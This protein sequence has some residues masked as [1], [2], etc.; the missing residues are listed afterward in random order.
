MKKSIIKVALFAA[1]AL[2]V[3]SCKSY[4]YQVYDVSSNNLKLQENS[5]VYE[6]E[7]CKVL[8]N[9]W[10]NNGK[11]KFAIINKTDKDIFVNM[12]Q[13]FY[14][15]NGQAV[16]YYQGRTYTT[17]SFNESTYVSTTASGSGSADGFWGKDVYFEDAQAFAKAKTFKFVK[18][19]ANSVTTKEK[20]IVCIPA[21]CYKI[22]NYYSVNPDRVITCERSKDYPSGNYPVGSYTQANT[23][24]SFKNRIAYGFTKNDVADKH[25][26]NDFWISG[27]TNYSQDA[28]TENYKDKKECYGIKSSEKGKRFKIGTPSKFY[29]LYMDERSGGFGNT[30]K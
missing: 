19:V 18:A 21:K 30:S 16:D 27:I 29:K 2:S 25:I 26:D 22:F 14:V 17:Q 23:P 10:S 5:L 12:G 3:S 13:S 15:V 1:I 20:E 7:D 8:Y 11:L 24:M 28:A 9:L 6:N 4:Y